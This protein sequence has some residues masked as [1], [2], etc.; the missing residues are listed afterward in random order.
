MYALQARFRITLQPES[1]CL[2]HIVLHNSQSLFN[3]IF[4]DFCCV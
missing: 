2:S 1:H 3:V 4:L